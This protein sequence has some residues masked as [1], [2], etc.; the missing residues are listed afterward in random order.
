MKV[1]YLDVKEC[2]WMVRWKS[3]HEVRECEWMVMHEQWGVMLKEEWED[4]KMKGHLAADGLVEQKKP[5]W[6]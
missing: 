4:E 2:E 5:Q 1:D 6:Q 3:H